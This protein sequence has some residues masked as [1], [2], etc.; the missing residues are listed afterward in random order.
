MAYLGLNDTN[1]GGYHNGNHLSNGCYP[2]YLCFTLRNICTQVSPRGRVG[3]SFHPFVG[4]SSSSTTSKSKISISL[5]A[6]SLFGN[7]RLIADSVFALP[8]LQKVAKTLSAISFLLSGGSPSYHLLIVALANGNSLT[9][10]CHI[11]AASTSGKTT[12]FLL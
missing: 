10:S 5:L 7:S 2:K 1:K 9:L 6:A 4:G 3:F 8:S 12:T 11:S